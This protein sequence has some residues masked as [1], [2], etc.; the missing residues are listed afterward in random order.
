MTT[1][2]NIPNTTKQRVVIIGGGFAGLKLA[3]SL[4]RKHFQI[5]LIDKNNY[6][7]FQPL[8]YQV[9]TSGLEPSAI[10][11]PFRKAFQKEKHIHFRV[12]RFEKVHP[13]S[14]T[15][16]TNIGTLDY[17]YLVL[18][19]GATTNYFGNKNIEQH[20]LS[21]KSTGEALA[22]RNTILTNFEKAL[23]TTDDVIK[24]SLMNIVLVGG[25]PTGVEL[26][27]AFAEMKKYILPKDYPELD[28]SQM[29]IHLLEA[30]P[31]ILNGYS[32]ESSKK[33]KAYLEKLGVQVHT[34]TFVEDYDGEKIRLKGGDTLYSKTL[35]WAA[36]IKANAVKGLSEESFGKAG[37][38]VVNEYSELKQHKN[39]FALGDIA[40]MT[41]PKYPNGHPQVAQVALQQ[42]SRLAKNLKLKGKNQPL[43]AFRYTD[44]GSLATVGRKL[45]VADLP[46]FSFQGFFAWILWLV[47]H[48]MAILGVKNKLMVLLNWT[49]SY[50]TYDQSL[51]LVIRPKEK[52]KEEKKGKQELVEVV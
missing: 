10:S 26:A 45:A 41:T 11:F 30:M 31:K 8:F 50:W 22:L 23:N 14:Q 21:M 33:G 48:L 52:K 16:E 2:A 18:A 25:G 19:M 7:Q 6:H 40:Y 4:P 27:G 9:A 32:E 3:Q 20:A 42:A 13:D 36:G 43:Q 15:I 44:K 38:L 46:L 49:W 12:A 47:V 39:I 17:D 28:F 37:R 34:N 24:E 51:R 35:I 5:V 1:I 29:Q